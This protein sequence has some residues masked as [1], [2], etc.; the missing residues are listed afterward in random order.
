MKTS[1]KVKDIAISI[2]IASVSILTLISLLA[3]WD[4][5][6]GDVVFKSYTTI[7]IIGFA[8]VAVVV[9]VQVMERHGIAQADQSNNNL[10]Q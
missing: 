6:E 5:F 8:S 10:T 1:E 4:I 2:F 9:A 7:G 3:I